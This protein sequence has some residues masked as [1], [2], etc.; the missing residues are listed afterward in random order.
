MFF[1]VFS[2]FSGNG[3]AFRGLIEDCN[4]IQYTRKQEFPVLNRKFHVFAKTTNSAQNHQFL[5]FCSKTPIK[6]RVEK[7]YRAEGGQLAENDQ[8]VRKWR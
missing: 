5:N 3:C 6:P 7:S 8:K 2:H 4:G 1:G